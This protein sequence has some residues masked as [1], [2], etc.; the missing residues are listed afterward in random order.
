MSN[1]TEE[2]VETI[3]IVKSGPDPFLKP[4]KKVKK[5]VK[6]KKAK[7]QF[8]RLNKKYGF[9]DDSK[10]LDDVLDFGYDVFIGWWRD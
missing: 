5:K 9:T 3:S 4:K 1:P 8:K 6:K 7:K 2:S 10:C